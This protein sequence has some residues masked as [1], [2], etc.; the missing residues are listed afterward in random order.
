MEP[1]MI[2]IDIGTNTCNLSCRYCKHLSLS[3]SSTSV[4]DHIKNVTKIVKQ[5]GNSYLYRFV[6]LSSEPLQWV[7]V[8]D[9]LLSKFN[10]LAIQYNL[11]WICNLISN[12]HLLASYESRKFIS[13]WNKN[14][15]LKASVDGS[16]EMHDYAKGKGSYDKTINSI[17]A[18]MPNGILDVNNFGYVVMPEMTHKFYEGIRNIIGLYEEAKAT[19]YH[20]LVV[21]PFLCKGWRDYT[22]DEWINWKENAEEVQNFLIKS[23]LKFDVNIIDINENYNM[24]KMHVASTLHIKP[25]KSK[26]TDKILS[27]PSIEELNLD[28]NHKKAYTKIKKDCL[29]CTVSN[30]N[31]CMIDR[32]DECDIDNECNHKKMLFNLHVRWNKI[33]NS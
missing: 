5:F 22:Y 2:Y 10:V 9:E 7:E 13:R 11:T 17:K 26:F 33:L 19:Q 4:D 21:E 14:I 28:E 15:L 31:T 29:H 23:K 18:Y 8:Y 30:W 24:A 6:M 25:D 3:G 16:R 1:F 12:C 32:V 27:N 20:R